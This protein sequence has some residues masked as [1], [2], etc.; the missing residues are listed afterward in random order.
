MLV[1]SMDK[2]RTLAKAGAACLSLT[3]GLAR[4][5]AADFRVT[6]YLQNPATN[7]MTIMWLAETSTVGQ[8]VFWTGDGPTTTVAS[9]GTSAST[10]D[11][12]TA[13]KSLSGG[14]RSIPYLH[15]ERV[16]N[17]SPSRTYR[18]RVTQGATTYSNQFRTA[19]A[20]YAPVRFAMYADSETEPESTAPTPEWTNPAN[21]INRKYLLSQTAGYASNT[22]AIKARAPDFLIIAGDLVEA[23][24]EQRDWDEFWRHNA[25][26]LNDLAG[27]IPILPALGNHEYHPGLR[28]NNYS[29]PHS[30]QSVSKYL[31]YFDLPPNGA[32][33][34]DQQ[35]RY[36]RIDYGPVS[37]IVLDTCNGND[38]AAAQDTSLRLWTST[39]CK[40]PD[41]NI[42]STQ[43]Q[44]LVQQLADA[45]TRSLFT[46]VAFHH[47]PY[48]SGVH[49]NANTGDNQLGSPIQVLTPTFLQ[50]GVDAV[51]SGHDEMVE[52]SILSGQETLPGG[53]QI[54]HAVHFYDY[55][56][57]GDGLRGPNS[58]S[59]NPQRT[60]LAHTGS[61][62]VWSGNTL[63][64]GGKHY[65]HLEINVTTNTTGEWIATLSPFYEFPIMSGTNFLS[66]ESRLYSDETVLTPNLIATS[67]DSSSSSSSSSTTSSSSSTTSDS[68][69]SDTTSSSSTSSSSS[70]SSS[71]TS[72]TMDTTTTTSSTTTAS[73]T[74]MGAV[75]LEPE[76]IGLE[77]LDMV[78]GSTVTVL[79]SDSLLDGDWR[80]G[81]QFMATTPSTNWAVPVSGSNRFY[82]VRQ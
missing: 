37:V 42:G 79:Y 55:G 53:A 69:T 11:Y 58:S 38:A 32:G 78:V 24:G 41:Y 50:Y 39:G 74:R 10:L 6:P 45:Q 52:H 59:P 66:T 4:A 25:G 34:V 18:Y 80:T 5:T 19:P 57:G 70:S 12:C 20:S 33:T 63:T 77:A 82:R 31:T 73:P 1:Y 14:N 30:E 8:L 35:E 76:S 3:T 7:A 29:Q 64:S 46:F 13:E 81:A 9:A 47:A 54:P 28:G 51:L 48:S 40:A 49:G 43:Y 22:A 61:P 44:W 26:A 60:F 2:L 17:L 56:V 67:S 71:S 16:N 65:G 72:T 62:E 23:A 21:G 36:Y 15:Q 68:T 27:Q 75:T